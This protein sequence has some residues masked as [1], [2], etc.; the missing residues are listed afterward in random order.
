MAEQQDNNSRIEL[1]EQLTP[2]QEMAV[3]LHETYSA[4]VYAG[5][6]ENQ[7]MELTMNMTQFG[8]SDEGDDD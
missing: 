5:F 3:V 7:A 8:I 4:F 2:L 1:V 6:N